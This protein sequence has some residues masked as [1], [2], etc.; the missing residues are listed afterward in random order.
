[1]KRKLL[2]V[3]FLLLS[4]LS[5]VLLSSCS[6][7]VT[8]TLETNTTAGTEKVKF[9]KGETIGDLLTPTKV[10]F[11]FDGWYYD[12]LF[13]NPVS[14]TDEVVKCTVYAKWIPT[15]YEKIAVGSTACAAIYVDGGLYTWGTNDKGVL[16]TG[17]YY[18][19]KEPVRIMPDKTFV[20]VAADNSLFVAIDSDGQLYQWGAICYGFLSGYECD[21]FNLPTPMASDVRF[22]QADVDD[23]N[24]LSGVILALDVDGNIW[25]WGDNQFKQL[26][27][28]GVAYS[29]T[30]LKIDSDYKFTK[31]SVG[32]QNCAA[33]TTKGILYTWGANGV[34]LGSS[35]K[36]TFSSVNLLS[37]YKV[38]IGGEKVKDV[39][40]GTL[41]GLALSKS[42]TVYSWGQNNKGEIGNGTVNSRDVYNSVVYPEAIWTSGE[43]IARVKAQG[44]TSL[45][46]AESGN[47][48]V[49]GAMLSVMAE[50]EELSIRT[51]PY[52]LYD[53]A[54][55]TYVACSLSGG[56]LLTMTDDGECFSSGNNAY[57]MI[58]NGES[59][60][61][62]EPTKATTDM[63]IE[64]YNTTNGNTVFIIDTDGQL[65]G[66]GKND[67]GQLG[68]GTTTDRTKHT[69]ILDGVKVKDFYEYN[70]NCACIDVD[71]NLYVWGRNKNGVLGT[72]NTDMILTP[73]KITES[74]FKFINLRVFG[75]A[76]DIYGNVWACGTPTREGFIGNKNETFG[77]QKVTDGVTFEYAD[78]TAG[79]LI[80]LDKNGDVYCLDA[81]KYSELTK[82]DYGTKFCKI[83]R[84][85]STTMLLS[86]DG[87]LYGYGSNY[88]GILNSDEDTVSAAAPS[89]IAEGVTEVYTDGKSAV[90]KKDGKY[91]GC[92]Y[93]FGILLGTNYVK[94]VEDYTP[95]AISVNVKKVFCSF[96]GRALF[97]LSDDNRLYGWGVIG[98]DIKEWNTM[99][100]DIY[101]YRIS[102]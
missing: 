50:S 3:V 86:T 29:K 76:I 97:V 34:G 2:V 89:L 70:G 68:D 18:S 64:Y 19:S 48:Y 84:A 63:S 62:T 31:V 47:V 79:D 43:K 14:S 1:M 53:D 67:Y 12:Q 100:S 7:R 16:G 81:N 69:K 96:S 46:I 15:V 91:Y 55:Y 21:E 102:F 6:G 51:V 13:K 58:G 71:G 60:A 73:T 24:G 93:Y 75:S 4:L 82:L 36:L 52:R 30:P 37:M 39:S 27:M 8:V 17:D 33:I 22:K 26:G 10:G 9:N 45:V 54:R 66:Y 65:W 85:G 90:I 59:Y 44:S 42:G 74:R 11:E 38:D 95:I 23:G 25:S 5:T 72:G 88:Y 101:R 41:Y 32:S 78:V 87:R 57:M 28:S 92:G 83:V 20:H 77:W 56:V 61:T 94:D 49:F 40:L 80:G 99:C 98:E 35:V